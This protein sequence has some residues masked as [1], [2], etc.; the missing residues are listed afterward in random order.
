A[1]AI[2][3]SVHG[4]VITARSSRDITAMELYSVTGLSLIRG[5]GAELDAGTLPAGVYLLRVTADDG[6]A[7]LRKLVLR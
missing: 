2:A 6:H 7:H 4:R 5:E 3:V 1:D